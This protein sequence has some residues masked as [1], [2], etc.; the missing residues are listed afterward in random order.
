MALQVIG[1]RA[2]GTCRR[3]DF[4]AQCRADFDSGRESELLG[5]L[6]PDFPG[7]FSDALLRGTAVP[8]PGSNGLQNM[9]VL[10]AALR[11]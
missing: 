5:G 1:Q 7:R 8:L 2:N 3:L 6:A 10:Q 4:P 11:P 9:R